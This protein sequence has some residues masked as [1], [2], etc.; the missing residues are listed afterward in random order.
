[1][2]KRISIFLTL[3]LV[4]IQS[5]SGVYAEGEDWPTIAEYE[6]EIDDSMVDGIEIPHNI[7]NVDIVDGNGKKLK[8]KVEVVASGKDVKYNK[9]I[10]DA[11]NLKF[12][13]ERGCRSYGNVLSLIPYIGPD[14][15]YYYEKDRWGRSWV[16]DRSKLLYRYDSSICDLKINYHIE[17]PKSM[18]KLHVYNENGNI[19]YNAGCLEEVELEIFNGSLL[20]DKVEAKKFELGLFEGSVAEIKNGIKSGELKME[21]FARSKMVVNGNIETEGCARISMFEGSEM[22]LQKGA[23]IKASNVIFEG[24]SGSMLNGEAEIEASNMLEIQAFNS[25]VDLKHGKLIGKMV[26]VEAYDGSNVNIDSKIEASSCVKLCGFSESAAIEVKGKVDT[27]NLMTEGNENADIRVNG[28]R[29]TH[30]SW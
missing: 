5:G 1:M 26:K 11:F 27:P 15:I 25:N 6:Y 7:G 3:L 8:V 24:F 30:S 23:V 17:V 13:K 21:G 2:K 19:A 18:K 16:G 22:N 14:E 20:S 10:T 28:K 4:V 12:E 29:I 9:K